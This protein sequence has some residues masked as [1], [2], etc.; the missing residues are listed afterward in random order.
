[1]IDGFA[2]GYRTTCKQKY[3]Y[4]EL[5]AMDANSNKIIKSQFSFPSSCCCHVKFTGNTLVRFGPG[6]HTNLNRTVEVKKG[7]G[8]ESESE[9]EESQ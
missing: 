6:L 7:G 5:A 9:S 4:R 8:Y 2:E 3:I 1:M